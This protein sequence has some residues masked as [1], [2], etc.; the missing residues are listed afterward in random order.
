MPARPSDPSSPNPSNSSSSSSSRECA[1]LLRDDR[2]HFRD[3]RFLGT[4]LE[5]HHI[6][7]VTVIKAVRNKDATIVCA[8]AQQREEARR[9]M[10]AVQGADG[11]AVFKSIRD[12]SDW[13]PKDRRGRKRPRPDTEVHPSPS[14]AADGVRDG[15]SPTPDG[16]SSLS[17]PSS[18]TSSRYARRHPVPSSD[19]TA[20]TPSSLSIADVVTP[21]HSLPYPTQ[22]KRKLRTAAT[23]LKAATKGIRALDPSFTPF[24]RHNVHNADILCDLSPPIASPVLQGYRN[25]CEFSVGKDREG[26]RVAGFLLGKYAEGVL[27]VAAVDEC[28]NVSAEAKAV[29]AGFTAFL[30]ASSHDVYDRISHAGVWR[31]LTVRNTR[32]GEVMAVVQLSPKELSEAEVQAVHAQLRHHFT[33]VT[34]VQVALGAAQR[35]PVQL[36]HLCTRPSARLRLHHRD[37][38]FPHVPHLPL[39]LLPNQHRRCRAALLPRPHPRLPHPP[40]HPAR[41]LLRHRHHRP[42]ARTPH[43]AHHRPRAVARR[44]RGRARQRAAQWADQH[45]VRGGEGGGHAGGGVEGGG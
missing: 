29:A 4:L 13:V 27:A 9:L 25:K 37:P 17:P 19:Q 3:F 20:T 31:M 28:V 1:L 32:A 35:R 26:K 23:A 6:P 33:A 42:A 40:H 14:A 12:A 30:Q 2:Y 45:E 16:V 8:D 22:L 21:Y 38:L 10:E 43:R 39:L 36:S 41:H 24:H 34:P 5:T 18:P 7:H 44:H 11:K 15:A